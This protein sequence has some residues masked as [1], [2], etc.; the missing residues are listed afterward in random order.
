MTVHGFSGV[1][2]RIHNTH[3]IL[4][5]VLS[6]ILD[7]L[8]LLHHVMHSDGG[9][10]LQHLPFCFDLAHFLYLVLQLHN[11]I[12]GIYHTFSFMLNASHHVPHCKF[13]TLNPFVVV[14][15]VLETVI[16]NV[17][18]S[19]LFLFGDPVAGSSSLQLLLQCV[20]PL[21]KCLCLLVILVQLHNAAGQTLE[22]PF[23]LL[24]IPYKYK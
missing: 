8:L 6:D 16:N 17:L 21:L 1:L 7:G 14:C 22:Y 3:L 13:Q 10:R 12:L 9:L 2:C 19:I 20:Q 15:F 18:E 23:P 4:I 24:S 5:E 11:L